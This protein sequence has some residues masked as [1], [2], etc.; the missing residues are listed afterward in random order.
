MICVFVGD[1]NAVEVVNGFF[2]GRKPRQRLAFAEPGVN[3]EAG[4]LRLEQG[5][6]ARAPGRQNGYPQ[7]YDFPPAPVLEPSSK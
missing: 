2:D 1:Q 4:T 3:E 5:D 6:V 7:P